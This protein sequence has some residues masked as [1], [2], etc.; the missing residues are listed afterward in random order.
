M[1]AALEWCHWSNFESGS[2]TYTSVVVFL[3]LGT[4]IASR[5]S[6][7]KLQ[8]ELQRTCCAVNSSTPIKE[9]STSG[10]NVHIY[11]DLR[12]VVASHIESG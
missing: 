3:P 9:H 4:L 11:G 5:I 2:L 6:Y 7:S 8:A 10:L 1:F 12:G